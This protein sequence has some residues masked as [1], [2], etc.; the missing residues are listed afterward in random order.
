MQAQEPESLGWRGRERQVGPGEDG[1]NLGGL[2]I[3]GQDVQAVTFGGQLTGQ[4]GH[5]E[6]GMSCG[7]VRGD[8]QVQGQPA[9]QLS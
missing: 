9:A 3:G 5:A 7:A 6:M 8:P 2:L 4:V 1:A